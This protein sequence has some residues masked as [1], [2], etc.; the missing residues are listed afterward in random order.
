MKGYKIFY[1]GK[2][3]RN[4]H[5]CAANVNYGCVECSKIKC[6]NYH[7]K[8]KQKMNERCKKYKENNKEKVSA[9]YK[10]WVEKN[11]ERKNCLNRNRKSL[12]NKNGGSHNHNDIMKIMFSQI[13][14]CNL[15][16][17]DITN[18][19]HVDHI[20]PLS[21]GGSNNPDNLQILCPTCNIK[22]KDKI[23]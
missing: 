2:P 4:G 19:Y 1:T 18:N 22:K 9:S 6:R 13:N 10:S 23:L 21:R 20:Y 11:R 15:C 7:N 12:I 3:C 14:L 16:K 5:V 8:N 17:C